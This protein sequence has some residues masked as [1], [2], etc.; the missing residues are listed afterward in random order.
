MANFFS[1]FFKKPAQEFVA[2]GS[3]FARHAV[4]EAELLEAQGKI[5]ALDTVNKVADAALDALKAEVARVHAAQNELAAKRT[6]LL[7][8]L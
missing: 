5:L 6:A 2:K 7:S 1:K 4:H 3:A 8:L